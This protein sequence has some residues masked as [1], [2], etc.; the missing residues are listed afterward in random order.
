VASSFI[1]VWRSLHFH[2][3]LAVRLCTGLEDVNAVAAREASSSVDLPRPQSERR[4]LCIRE[5][6]C[7]AQ[8]RTFLACDSYRSKAVLATVCVSAMWV[9][10]LAVNLNSLSSCGCPGWRRSK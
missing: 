6:R 9:A 1:S 4:G 3:R 10:G 8:A 2:S 7:S 5:Q